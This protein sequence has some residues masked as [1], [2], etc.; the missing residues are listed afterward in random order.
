MC[1]R[2]RRAGRLGGY[3]RTEALTATVGGPIRF[4]SLMASAP[5]FCNA[6]RN[7]GVGSKSIPDWLRARQGGGYRPA[8]DQAFE[9]AL[10][11]RLIGRLRGSTPRRQTQRC[12]RTARKV[13]FSFI[14]NPGLR[15][16]TARGPGLVWARFRINVCTIVRCFEDSIKPHP[17][18]NPSQ[19]SA[20]TINTS[21]RSPKVQVHVSTSQSVT[22]A[23]DTQSRKAADFAALRNA[24]T[25]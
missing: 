9:L 2:N 6:S 3:C 12:G 14:R 15:N 18:G 19:R 22:H 10:V 25:L 5:A 23:D 8:V 21:P 4:A 13:I 20:F 16:P 24:L 17:S 7:C 11:E 1:H